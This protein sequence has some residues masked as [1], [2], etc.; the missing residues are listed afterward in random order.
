MSQEPQTWHYGLMARWRVSTAWTPLTTIRPLPPGQRRCL[1][2]DGQDRYE[3]LG[4]DD[5]HPLCRPKYAFEDR[6]QAEI[7]G[8]LPEPH[9]DLSR[10]T[11]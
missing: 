10:T 1:Q 7:L 5:G 11:I 6:A 8:Q 2:R 4:H 9:A 3:V